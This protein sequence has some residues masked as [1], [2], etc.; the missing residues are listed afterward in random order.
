MLINNSGSNNTVVGYEALQ[1]NLIGGNNTAVGYE[2]LYSNTGGNNTALGATALVFNVSGDSNTAVGM[3]ALDAN[4]SGSQN[5]AVGLGALGK[6][7]GA[8]NGNVAIGYHAGNTLTSGAANIYVGADAATASESNTIRVG[9]ATQTATY[10]AGISGQTVA[11]GV[12]VI[13]DASGHL[14]TTTSSRRYK[15]DIRDMG[16]LSDVLM[17]LRPVTFRYKK[18]LDPEGIPQYGLVAEE[19]A[20]VRPDLVVYKNGQPETVRYQYVNAM[21]LNEVQRQ[22]RHIDALEQ[23]LT[24]TESLLRKRLSR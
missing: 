7:A 2:A 4:N 22:R 13:V 6:V 1:A 10:I 11:G 20:K 16:D 17:S 14:G 12:G 24:R 15:D 23:R 18:E 3:G 5:T 19:V 8:S 21:L 9:T